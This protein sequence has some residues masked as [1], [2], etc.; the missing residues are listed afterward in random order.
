M[1]YDAYVLRVIDDDTIVCTISLGFGIHITR[2]VRL[3]GINAPEKNTPEGI[4]AKNKLTLLIDK[5]QIQL[6]CVEQLDK[7]GRVLGTPNHNGINI[8]ELLLKEGFAKPML[9]SEMIE[10]A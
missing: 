5:E 4:G 1:M 2:H 9:Y 8:C 10:D 3:Y 6:N 7:Y